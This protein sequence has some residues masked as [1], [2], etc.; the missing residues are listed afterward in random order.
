MRRICGASNISKIPIGAIAFA[1]ENAQ[2]MN[3]AAH[4][5]DPIDVDTA[6]AGAYTS[7]RMDEIG[8]PIYG[9][10]IEVY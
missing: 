2:I 6:I 3:A 7:W 5:C 10:I 4:G 8:I 9:W 1:T